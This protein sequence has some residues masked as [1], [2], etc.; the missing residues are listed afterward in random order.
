PPDPRYHVAR[1]RT[2][3][4]APLVARGLPGLVRAPKRRRPALALRPRLHTA[5]AAGLA[6]R[7]PRV[8]AH[9]HAPRPRVACTGRRAT[10][11][12]AR[13]LTALFPS[14]RGR[15]YCSAPAVARG[16]SCT[17]GRLLRHRR[18]RRLFPG[19]EQRLTGPPPGPAP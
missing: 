17:G 7:R 9:R 19:R 1:T 16:R 18:R 5:G 6:A 12:V 2:A 14:S 15:A 4:R 3:A 11:L 13:H 8:R 10:R